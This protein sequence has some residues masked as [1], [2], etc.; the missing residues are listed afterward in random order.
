MVDI[1]ER[2]TA[3]IVSVL[4][5]I[6][7]IPSNFDPVEKNP[8]NVETE[9]IEI[10]SNNYGIN[11]SGKYVFDNSAGF[12]VYYLTINQSNE[13][14]E[15]AESLGEDFFEENNLIIVD[16]TLS[17]TAE[18]AF[19]SSVT[20][21]GDT[22]NLQYYTKDVADIGCCVICYDSICIKTSKQITKVN[23]IEIPA[24]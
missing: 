13:M 8:V 11:T 7:G 23:A 15:Y 2:I 22:L 19:V 10:I 17:D 6:F 24:I 18:K 14:R 21:N 1:I 3:F 5:M 4:I 12:G 9:N 16:V 20:E